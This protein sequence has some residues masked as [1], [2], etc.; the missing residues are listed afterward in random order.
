MASVMALIRN[1]VTGTYLAN[2]RLA[3]RWTL[4]LLVAVGFIF[5]LQA[6][7]RIDQLRLWRSPDST[8]LVFDLSEAV[9]HSL[10]ELENPHRIVLDMDPVAVG[11]ATEQIDLANTPLAQIRT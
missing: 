2:A 3:G 5:P 1:Q 4:C 10:F 11:A 6:E 7:P 8:R 9:D